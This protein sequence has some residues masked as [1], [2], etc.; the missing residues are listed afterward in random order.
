M[1]HVVGR[2]MEMEKVVQVG[3]ISFLGGAIASVLAARAVYQLNSL[4]Y[5]GKVQS[6]K[7]ASAKLWITSLGVPKSWFTHFYI[8]STVLCLALWIYFRLLDVVL[9]VRSIHSVRRLVECLVFQRG[10]SRSSRIQ[11]PHY[12]VGIGFYIVQAGTVW[13]HLTSRIEAVVAP[14]ARVI[15]SLCIIATASMYQLQCHR[16]LA[17]LRKYSLP[18]WG[19]FKRVACPHYLCEIALYMGFWMLDATP[20][21][22][23]SL[24]WVIVNLG[25]S[26]EQTRD[27]YRHKFD[28][29]PPYA[30][31]PGVF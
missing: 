27:Y 18:T 2:K 1:D 30:L 5:Y 3:S 17:S 13:A 23:L 22:A 12:V 25:A 9:T 7:P 29:S 14:W 21:T 10:S 20:V 19:L 24:L 8:V 31:I 15:L 4:L 11:L 28:N 16:H 6:S 26:A